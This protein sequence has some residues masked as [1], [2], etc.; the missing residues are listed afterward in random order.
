MQHNSDRAWETARTNM[1]VMCVV[2]NSMP[3]SG[4]AEH[5]VRNMKAPSYSGVLLLYD[6]SSLPSASFEHATDSSRAGALQVP[7]VSHTAGTHVP[8]LPQPVLWSGRGCRK[9]A[10]LPTGDMAPAG[11]AQWCILW[12]KHTAAACLPAH[13][14]HVQLWWEM[15]VCCRLIAL[16]VVCCTIHT[17]CCTPLN[18]CKH[19]HDSNDNVLAALS[20]RK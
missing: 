12:H 8:L 5:P 20:D 1:L 18:F 14:L 9:L 13:L 7:S 19:L 11:P 4:S 6:L 3:H 16:K 17:V 2:T 15:Q 10:D